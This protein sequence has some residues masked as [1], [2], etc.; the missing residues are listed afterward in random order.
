MSKYERKKPCYIYLLVTPDRYELPLAVADGL[1][2]LSRITGIAAT[3]L[4][5]SVNRAERGRKRRCNNGR[6][7]LVEVR[8]V[9]R[10]EEADAEEKPL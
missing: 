6:K 3:T 1:M 7:R 4:S 8:R 10:T 9:L 2:E 5:H